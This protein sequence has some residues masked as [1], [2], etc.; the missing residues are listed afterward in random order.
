[1]ARKLR[2]ELEGGLYHVI[3]RGNDRQDI[4]HCA[5]DHLKFLS[6]MARQKERLPFYLYA[7]CLMT[8]HIHLLIE[9]QAETV[10]KIMQRVLT[11]YSQYYNRKYKHVGHVFQGRHKS[12]LCQ[13]DP[14]LGELV[15]YI[16][17]NPLRAKMVSAAEDY[18]YSSQRAYL[19]LQPAAIV[20]V[21]PVLRHFGP[22]K[23]TA[24][25][26]FREF[27]SAGVGL[28]YPKGFDSPAEGDI[29][30]SEEFVDEAIHRIGDVAK[31]SQRKPKKQQ[32]PFDAEALIVSVETVFGLSRDKFRGAVKTANAVMA[33]EVLIVTGQKA[34][35]SLADI[36]SIIDLDT[37]TVSRRNDAA[38]QSVDLNSKLAFAIKLVEQEYHAK[39]AELQD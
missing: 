38:R 3:T 31:R 9:R 6:L 25:R 27:V 32:R 26:R 28:E 19:G 30:G 23:E 24:R 15:R 37:S 16:H 10:G 8:N 1:M 11:G 33:K 29:L 39:I 22:V 35:A 5:A 17:L 14:Y 20:D 7:Y 13:S 4:F 34:G 21:D 36:S 18:P 2:I 12:I